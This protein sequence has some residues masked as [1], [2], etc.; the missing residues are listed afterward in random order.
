MEVVAEGVET[1]DQFQKVSTLGCNFVQGYYFARP[2]A[3]PVT[4]TLMQE[5]DE[6]ERSFAILQGAFPRSAGAAPR[7]VPQQSLVP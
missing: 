5:R 7:E 4:Q 6:L 2:A 3:A 1:K